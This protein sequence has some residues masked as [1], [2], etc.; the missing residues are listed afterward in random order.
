M[1]VSLAPGL[2]NLYKH[3]S[4]QQALFLE[5]KWKKD[6]NYDKTKGAI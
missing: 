5:V 1:F 4:H 2:Q 3:Q 6:Y